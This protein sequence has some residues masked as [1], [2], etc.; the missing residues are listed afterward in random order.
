M[1]VDCQL[2]LR[3]E[4]VAT[5][6]E[7][8]EAERDENS[9]R[10]D[11]TPSEAVAA[12]AIEAVVKAEM[13]ANMREGGRIGAELTNEKLGRKISESGLS[14]SDTP[15]FSQQE[16]PKEDLETTE[17]RKKR[18]R[19]DEKIAKAI[20]MKRD[21]YRKA[22]TVVE[23][24]Q[25]DPERFAAIQE[26]MDRTG[27]VDA[28]Y[29]KVTNADK[30]KPKA[31]AVQDQEPETPCEPGKPDREAAAPTMPTPL[32]LLDQLRAMPLASG[33]PQ[34]FAQPQYRLIKEGRRR[35]DVVPIRHGAGRV[36]EKVAFEPPIVLVAVQER[37]TQLSQLLQRQFQ[38]ESL[39]DVNEVAGEAI[40]LN[41]LAV[42]QFGADEGLAAFGEQHALGAGAVLL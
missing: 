14:D 20:G 24:A 35:Y 28:A 15:D 41:E 4:N 32:E 25:E 9:C 31:A 16:T 21:R 30:P 12:A 39:L 38:L 36:S 23:A 17:E 7:C 37:R 10:K 33:L 18:H 27:K 5:T 42:S 6:L 1:T 2:A 29:R 13:E 8:L 3:T 34:L 26:E 22:K 40:G 19:A 11:F